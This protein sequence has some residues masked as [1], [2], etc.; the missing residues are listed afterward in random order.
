MDLSAYALS[1]FDS[2][3]H[4][5]LIG[6]LTRFVL[7]GLKSSDAP[8]QFCYGFIEEMNRHGHELYS[9]DDDDTFQTWSSTRDVGMFIHFEFDVEE[10]TFDVEIEF[11]SRGSMW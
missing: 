9:F 8:A 4:T 7:A 11:G 1:R 3:D 6:D 5:E 2:N 10:D